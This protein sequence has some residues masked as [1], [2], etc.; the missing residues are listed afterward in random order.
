MNNLRF[1]DR[2]F[3]TD[4]QFETFKRGKANGHDTCLVYISKYV[5]LIS[6]TCGSLRQFQYAPATYVN[7]INECISPYF[8][9]QMSKLL[10]VFQFNEH[11][12]M[13]KIL[14]SLACTWITIVDLSDSLSLDV[15]LE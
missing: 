7:S 13:N 2:Y 1:S 15:S 5:S 3:N 4:R 12:E 9:S 8:F 6:V 11:V 14:C 10:L